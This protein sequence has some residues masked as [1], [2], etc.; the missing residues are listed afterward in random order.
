MGSATHVD[1]MPGKQR[2]SARCH[3]EVSPNVSQDAKAM[4]AWLTNPAERG[5]MASTRFI[6]CSD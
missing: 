5:L 6:S 1:V 4:G 3:P 2:V